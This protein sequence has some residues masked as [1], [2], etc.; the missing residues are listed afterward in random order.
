MLSPRLLSHSDLQPAGFREVSPLAVLPHLGELRLVDVREPD[1]FTGP[2]GHIPGAQL[3]PLGTVPQAA[4]TWDRAAPI[5]LICRSGARSGRAA[6]WLASQ[7][8]R[9]AFNLTGGMLAWSA[10]SLPRQQRGESPLAA[11]VGEVRAYFIAAADGD[12]PAAERRFEEAIGAGLCTPD[13]LRRAVAG[14]TAPDG[15][16]PAEHA[17]WRAR[18]DTRLALAG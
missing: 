18:M 9:A 2:L 4:A 13:A 3:A 7:G 5:L 1:E 6:A 15:V 16:S 14:L 11:I 17:A 12:A 8:F 10:N